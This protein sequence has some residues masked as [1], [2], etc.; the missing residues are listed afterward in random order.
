MTRTEIDAL[1]TRVDLVE[2]I[3]ATGVELKQSGQ[4]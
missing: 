2:V 3:R 1:K 4:S